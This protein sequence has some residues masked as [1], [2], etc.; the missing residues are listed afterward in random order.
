[1]E[2][3]VTCHNPGTVDQDS[4]ESLDMA[5]MVHSI[6][7]GEDREG[8]VPFD[9]LGILGLLARLLEVT[10]PQSKAYCETCHAA[11]EAAPDGDGWQAAATAKT[12]GG[13]HADGLV[14]ANFDVVT[15]Q[16]EYSVR[17]CHFRHS[18]AGRSQRRNCNGCHLG[19]IDTAGDALSIHS[20][21]S[22]D[23][24]FREELGK[25]FVFEILSATG[26]GPGE[27]PVIT[28][29]VTNAAGTAYDIMTAPEFDVANGS[30]MNLY[31]AWPGIENYNGGE[32]GA[33]GGFRLRID[34]DDAVHPGE[35]SYYGAGHPNRMY[36]DVIQYY[37]EN[38][39]GGINWTTVTV[40]T[41]STT[42]RRC[43]KTSPG[44]P[45][46][47]WVDIRQ[48]SVSTRMLIRWRS[49]T[50]VPP[51]PALSGTRTAPSVNSPFPPITAMPA[52]SSCSSTVQ[53]ATTN[54]EMCLVCH[55]A[56]LAAIEDGIEE[57]FALGRM[58]HAIHAASP[59]WFGGEF[60][61]VTYPQSIA[62]C[63]TCHVAGSYNA[64]RE[65]AR[66]V[67]LS[68]GLEETVWT[69]DA[70][71]TPTSQ[72]CGTCHMSVAA[73]GHFNTQGGAVAIEKDLI[74]KVGG[75]P[76]GQEACAVCHGPGNEFD[77]AKYH[78]PGIAE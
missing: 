67:S 43:P 29:S 9:D 25:E 8:A 2:Y 54:P 50:S 49:V 32:G 13:C 55:N 39:V 64:A 38:A 41:R 16:A 46:S 70:A 58:I 7:M 75:L 72:A 48:R 56:D 26:T 4:G 21:L 23:Q 3:C 51:Q 52:T 65:E 60:A 33:T 6:H 53:I 36:L 71:T 44:R 10:Y 11:S 74:Q 14:A 18:G 42:S 62:N 40:A 5:Y 17:P 68:L 35:P 34:G 24:R 76:N 19:A 37:I 61:G 27:T 69:D 78:N 57:G 63:D 30:S 15:G 77:T 20:R 47:R 45:W 12:C 73:M 66:S 1:M 31:V 28:F 22:G 59:S